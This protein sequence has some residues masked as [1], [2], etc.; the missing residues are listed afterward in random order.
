MTTS[1]P[2]LRGATIPMVPGRAGH[3]SENPH[4]DQNDGMFR[5]KCAIVGL[6]KPFGD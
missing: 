1:Q 3:M 4:S 5:W 2:A 6:R